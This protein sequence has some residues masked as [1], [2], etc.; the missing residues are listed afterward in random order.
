MKRSNLESYESICMNCMWKWKRS[1]VKISIKISFK[2]NSHINSSSL[3]H[4]FILPLC[5]IIVW[6]ERYFWSKFIWSKCSYFFYSIS[7]D[8][9]L[10]V[11]AHQHQHPFPCHRVKGP[12][13]QGQ[14]T[15]SWFLSIISL[16]SRHLSKVRIDQIP[17]IFVSNLKH[18]KV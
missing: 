12:W 14:Q 16:C 2:I 1:S 9:F 6:K 15:P 4:I 8:Q 7:L 11:W 5:C 13:H 18:K 17:Y 3:I 10:F